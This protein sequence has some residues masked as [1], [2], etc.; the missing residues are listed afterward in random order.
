MRRNISRKTL[1]FNYRKWMR[2][3]ALAVSVF[4]VVFVLAWVYV[5]S[6]RIEVFPNFK[7]PLMLIHPGLIPLMV[8]FILSLW[9]LAFRESRRALIFIASMMI[10]TVAMAVGWTSIVWAIAAVSVIV[11]LLSRGREGHEG[12]VIEHEKIAPVG[13]WLIAALYILAGYSALAP[14]LL[15]PEISRILNVPELSH[16]PNVLLFAF[17]VSLL[18]AAF[19]VITMKKRWFYITMGLSALSIGVFSWVPLFSLF[20]IPIF[21]PAWLVAVSPWPVEIPVISYLIWKRGAFLKAKGESFRGEHH[22][23]PSEGSELTTLEAC[24]RLAL[25]EQYEMR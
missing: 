24:H 19:G 23:A 4:S 20:P 25:R 12:E 8:C 17:G 21:Y 6:I 14:A 18:I 16:I 5:L 7:V 2:K 11:L 10:I 15:T 13:V 9:A 22:L 1:L 3:K